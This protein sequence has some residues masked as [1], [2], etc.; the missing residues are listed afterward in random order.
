[1]KE[2]NTIINQ[3]QGQVSQAVYREI[4]LDLPLSVETV[5][6]VAR[7]YGIEAR[8]FNRMLIGGQDVHLN[9]WSCRVKE[10]LVTSIDLG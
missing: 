5:A 8:F 3:I 6:M 7:I 10:G 1:M 9:R 2:L 4:R